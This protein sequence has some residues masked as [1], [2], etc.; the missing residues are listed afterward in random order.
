MNKK[1]D[2]LIDN[3]TR[4]LVALPIGKKVITCKWVFKVK[5]KDD[6]FLEKYKVCLMTK[7]YLYVEGLD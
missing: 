3:G 7:G 5:L 2:I 6:R 1:F 4:E